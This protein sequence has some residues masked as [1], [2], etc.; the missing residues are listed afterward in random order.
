MQGGINPSGSTHTE[1]HRK[2]DPNVQR[3]F[4]FSVS[5]SCRQF[6]YKS[7]GRVVTKDNSYLESIAPI[8]RGSQHLCVCVS[9]QQFWLQSNANRTHGLRCSVSHKTQPTKTFGEHS[10]D[11]FYL[12]TSAEHYRM[13]VIFCK[14]TQAK[15]LADTV[16]F[17]HKHITQPM[18][19]PADAIVNAFTKLQDAIQGIQHSKDDAH[20]E[21]LWQFEH[22]L[23]PPN[24]HAIKSVK[25]VKLPRVE[26]QIELTQQVPRVRFDNAP[27][28]VHDPPPRLIVTSPRKQIVEPQP[29]PILKPPKYID[30]SVAARVQARRLQS[31][32]TVNESIAERVARR[33][34][35]AAIAVLDQDTRQLLEY[36]R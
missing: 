34:R 33:R 1:C 5:R 36:R 17:K 29:K 13:H 2:S 14:K 10:E 16:F 18:V 6:S 21:A 22:T 25:H 32:T 24:K 28:T 4:H 27:P 8:K 35:E 9:S 26:Q 12:K 30:K 7:M 23:Q 11:G 31:Q 20:F 3:T 15:Q 19:T